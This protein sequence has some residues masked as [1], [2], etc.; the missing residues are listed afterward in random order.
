MADMER[1]TDGNLGR[2]RTAVLLA[3]GIAALCAGVA[4]YALDRPPASVGFLPHGLAAGSG[5]FGAL[6]GPLP[7]FVHSMAFALITAALLAPTRRAALL[8][9]A[10]WAAINIVFEVSQHPIFRDFAG[11]GLRGS[12][13]PF[14]LLAAVLGA[15][16]AYLLARKFQSDWRM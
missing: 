11:F 2:R 7:T 1:R 15:A 6:S 12:Y 8:A 3:S 16:A 13:D 10:A 4:V 9:C 5:M 14:D